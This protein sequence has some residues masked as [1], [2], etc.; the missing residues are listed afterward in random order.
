M[1]YIAL[2]SPSGTVV[3]TLRA[4]LVDPGD[5]TPTKE[6]AGSHLI[7]VID[8]SGSMYRDMPV[9]KA[10]LVKLLALEEYKNAALLVSLVSYSSSG[11]TYTHIRR[12]PVADILGPSGIGRQAIENLRATNL[13][14]ISGGLAATLDLVHD[15]ESTTVVLHSDGYANDP[16][17]YSES[18]EVG[19]VLDKLTAKPGVMVS[20]VCYGPADFALLDM[21]ASRGGGVCVQAKSAG[22]VFDALHSVTKPAVG[23][24]TAARRFEAKG[25]LLVG[26]SKSARKVMSGQ[27]ELV[28]KGLQATDD[29]AVYEYDAGR[30]VDRGS[31]FN[32]AA[33]LL[34]ARAMLSLGKYNEAK[35]AVLGLRATTL[36]PHLRALTSPQIAEFAQALD[37]ASFGDLKLEF[38]TEHGVKRDGATILDVIEVLRQHEGQYLVNVPMLT[39]GRQRRS[40]ARK[41]GAWVNGA[42]VPPEYTTKVKDPSPWARVSSIEMSRTAATINVNI[43]R[44]VDLI[45]SQGAVVREVAGVPLALKDY[46]NITIV[47]EG[48]PTIDA[49]YLKVADK[50]LSKRLAELG[51]HPIEGVTT[52]PLKDMPVVSPGEVGQ[53]LVEDK[54]LF[55]KLALCAIARKM[56]DASLE[57]QSVKY[58]AAQVA[59]FER[60]CLSKSLNYNPPTVNPYE[61]RAAA[62]SRGEIDSY[63]TYRIELGAT[64]LLSLSDLPSANEFLVRRFKCMASNSEGRAE[65]VEKP[66]MQM[67]ASGAA[68]VSVK[69][70]KEIKRLK[71]GIADDLMMPLFVAFFGLTD[72]DGYH[73]GRERWA[74]L[75]SAAGVDLRRCGGLHRGRHFQSVE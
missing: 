52:I 70:D 10:T 41:H 29:L 61:D 69:G 2:V 13:T 64:K 49:I 48:N 66:T 37:A 42:V 54:Q 6:A 51:F 43:T 56:L 72:E 57:G 50:R 71:L 34:Y 21:I 4:T 59:E 24:A 45:D 73:T 25:K 35:Q 63:T 16:S 31:E 19:S 32:I 39:E 40:I 15:D 18:R 17:P 55:D 3:R 33:T 68:S 7:L 74:D 8:Q 46:R 9:M 1:S 22:Q 47:G 38:A 30:G 14:C 53:E 28:V 20:T 26:Y 27:D 11:E 5:N 36:Y 62:I 67:V 12:A 75:L 58:T 23:S 44:D 60:H 65:P